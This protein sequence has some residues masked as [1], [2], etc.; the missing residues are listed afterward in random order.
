MNLTDFQT[1]SPKTVFERIL[2][3]AAAEGVAVAESELI[4][5]IPEAALEGTSGE[6]LRIKGFDPSRM[7]LERRLAAL[8][9]QREDLA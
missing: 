9:E 5:L 3:E 1:T 2:A 8:L 6:E 4:G 7:I